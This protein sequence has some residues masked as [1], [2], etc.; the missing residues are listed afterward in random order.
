MTNKTE[1]V[2]QELNIAIAWDEGKYN[3]QQ[4]Q[5]TCELQGLDFNN[6]KDFYG[7]LYAIGEAK[8][9]GVQV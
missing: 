9:S 2:Q 3:Y 1:T 4:A 8:S 7:E 5:Y 6:V